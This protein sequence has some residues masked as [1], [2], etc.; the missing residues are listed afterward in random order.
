MNGQSGGRGYLLQAMVAVLDALKRE[1][2]TLVEIEP[3]DADERVD[4]RWSTGDGVVRVTQVK[5]SENAIQRADVIRWLSAL[6]SGTPDAQAYELILLG[7][8]SQGV[9][10]LAKAS[11][12][13][14]TR[15]SEK[16][17][18]NL[19]T[20]LASRF[21]KITIPAVQP[22]NL[23]LLNDV[24]SE[25]LE[26][27]L[28]SR[29][30]DIPGQELR[31]L[32]IARLVTTLF[33]HATNGIPISRYS[34]EERIK[35]WA[36]N[37]VVLRS[38]PPAL[39]P[40]RKYV[41]IV[42]SAASTTDRTILKYS[43][44]L[45]RGL[46]RALLESG[47]GLVTKT[48]PDPVADPSNPEDTRLLFYW[49]VLEVLDDYLR[50]SAESAQAVRQP[51]ARIVYSSKMDS[52]IPEQH[53]PLWSRLVE[54]GAIQLDFIYPGWNS[55]AF[56]RIMEVK[57]GD[58]LVAL[59]GGEG[60]EHLA[61]LYMQ[62]GKPVIPL[63]LPIPSMH[64]DGNGGAE[65][66]ARYALSRPEQYIGQLQNAA[67]RLSSTLTRRGRIP[68]PT[69][70]ARIVSLLQD[71]AKRRVFCIRLTEPSSPEFQTVETFFQDIVRPAMS[72]MGYVETGIGL[73]TDRHD[74]LSLATLRSIH[75]SS[76]V[77]ADL[78]ELTD[79]QL[80]ILGYAISHKHAVM[81]TASSEVAIPSD[82]AILPCFRW[83]PTASQRETFEGFRR[84][85]MAQIEGPP[86]VEPPSIP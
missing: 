38:I 48:G 72:K 14:V 86:L 67:V 41:Q 46:T 63:D 34:L 50:T 29:Q 70:C 25:R 83:N 62:E 21:D 60:V 58:A 23:E 27:F 13:I 35:D 2:W 4:I 17:K 76:V 82:L 30:L 10:D 9:V 80:V 73:G 78:T 59:G 6:I 32:I 47:F 18:E 52:L 42:G 1:D 55:G 57:C 11:R 45:V 54:M 64:G 16:A 7:G 69:V 49:D 40:L 31:R 8:H 85:W 36:G 65:Q 71:A 3:N 51:L 5:S 75:H 79:S 22:L 81:A 53:R 24:A 44:Q 56:R 84:Y 66:L 39:P 61:L 28:Q 37:Y 74:S 15:A 26:R 19:P 77:I 33:E 43:H 20:L 12:G 68:A